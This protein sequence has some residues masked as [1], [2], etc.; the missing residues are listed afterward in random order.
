MRLEG[1]GLTLTL[2]CKELACKGKWDVAIKGI[3]G[4]SG[5]LFVTCLF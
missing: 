1:I 3:S 5:V 2:A 4:F